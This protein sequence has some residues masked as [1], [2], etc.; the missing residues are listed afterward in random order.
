MDGLVK[1]VGIVEGLVGEVMRLEIAP[2]D[3]DV[4]QLW[5]IFGK[6]LDGE[7]MSA[8]GERCLGEFAGVDWAV[9]LDEHD[10]LGGLSRR[11]TVEPIKLFEMG[12]EVATALG[13][14]GMHDELAGRVIERAQHRDLL[15]LSRRGNAQVRPRLCPDASQVSLTMQIEVGTR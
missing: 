15:R 14:A 5:R 7:P 3:F 11:G 8:G 12:D 6:P 10:R 13:S 4:I 2:D 9:I 1:G